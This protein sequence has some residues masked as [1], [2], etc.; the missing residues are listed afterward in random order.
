MDPRKV[1]MAKDL[2]IG[3]IGPQ[4]TKQGDEGMLLGRGAG[5]GGFAIGIETSLIA[6]AN[7]M[8]IITTGMGSNHLLGTARVEFAIL[9]DVVMVAG[10]LVTSS[11][12]TGFE[13]FRREVAGDASG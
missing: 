1:L 10:G 7:G 13:V 9:G 12:V 8:G 6:N 3:I 2:G 11:L 4:S 5:V